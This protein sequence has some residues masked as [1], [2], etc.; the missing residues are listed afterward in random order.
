[1]DSIFLCTEGLPK[2]E[3]HKVIDNHSWNMTQFM[4]DNPDGKVDLVW[5]F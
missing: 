5:L 3:I 4:M 2:Y 1:M